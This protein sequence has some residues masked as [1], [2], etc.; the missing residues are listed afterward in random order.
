MG[1]DGQLK[2]MRQRPG[3]A[4]NVVINVKNQSHAVTAEV[5]SPRQGARGVILAQGGRFGGWGLYLNKAGRP[6]C[7]YNFWVGNA[8][9]LRPRKPCLQAGRRPASSLSTIMAVRAK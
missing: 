4:E 7:T 3:I 5:E 2:L 6:A 8:I 9:R 1:L